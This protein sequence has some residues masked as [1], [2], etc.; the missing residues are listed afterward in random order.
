MGFF[1][2]FFSQPAPCDVCQLG[3]ARWPRDRTGMVDWTL[4]GQGL[5]VSLRICPGCA[6]AISGM[7]LREKNPMMGLAMMVRAGR[8]E[9]PPVHYYLQHEAW[10][11]VWLEVLERFGVDHEDEFQALAEMKAIEGR[12][13]EQVFEGTSSLDRDPS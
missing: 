3:Q 4:Q 6:N 10:R 9:R 1:K 5:N 2:D 8:A 13:F 12:F 11:R 7:G